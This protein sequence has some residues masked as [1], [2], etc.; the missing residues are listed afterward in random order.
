MRNKSVKSARIT[1]SGEPGTILY[2]LKSA[3][4]ASFSPGQPK[5]EA[6]RYLTFSQSPSTVNMIGMQ[7]S[8]ICPATPSPG[9]EIDSI[10]E[11]KRSLRPV[12]DSGISATSLPS[13]S[14]MCIRESD[15]P[16]KVA[17]SIRSNVRTNFFI[18]FQSLFYLLDQKCVM[19]PCSGI[20]GLGGCSQ[21]RERFNQ[22]MVAYMSGRR[23][24][25]LH[26]CKLTES[27]YFLIR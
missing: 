3:C 14:E 1:P 2:R 19:S 24:G 23:D 13:P 16:V 9:S 10:T 25:S 4:V 26:T 27:H 6:F 12:I 15:L 5:R 21:D 18:L 11:A 7:L 8:D 20:S 17:A 22:I